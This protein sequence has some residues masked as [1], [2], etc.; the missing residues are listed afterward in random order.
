MAW[1]NNDDLYL[2]YGVEKTIPQKGGEY[3]NVGKLREIEIQL[4]LTALTESETIQSDTIFVPKNVRIAEVE[5]LTH[6]AAATGVAIDVGLVKA[7][8][9]TTNGAQAI[10]A[11]FVTASMNTDGDAVTLHNDDSTAG[12]MVGSTNA[13]VSYITASR[14][15][16]TAFTTGLVSVFIRYYPV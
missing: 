1:M 2:K 13:D 9:S 16:S 5:V 14:T 10:L 11:A 8:R 4:D 6:T 7:D 15:T 3:R 12:T